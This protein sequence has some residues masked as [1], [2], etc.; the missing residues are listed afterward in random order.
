LKINIFPDIVFE[1]NKINLDFQG[2][3]VKIELYRFLVSIIHD[4]AVLPPV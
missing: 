4:V 1:T 3:L 2:N